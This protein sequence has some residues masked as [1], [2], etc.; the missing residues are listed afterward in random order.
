MTGLMI[1][2]PT[3]S[4]VSSRLSE[5][6]SLASDALGGYFDISGGPEAK[7]RPLGRLSCDGLNI[8]ECSP[9]RGIGIP[10]LGGGSN[11]RFPIFPDGYSG[12]VMPWVVLYLLY[13]HAGVGFILPDQKLSLQNNSRQSGW[14][15]DE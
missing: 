14:Y 7:G 11:P 3:F 8:P 4:N 6:S 12:I 15:K 2:P 13:D 5:V 10:I 9:G 1:I